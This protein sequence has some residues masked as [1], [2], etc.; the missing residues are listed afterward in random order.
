VVAKADMKVMNVMTTT[1]AAMTDAKVNRECLVFS[2]LRERSIEGKTVSDGFT[3]LYRGTGCVQEQTVFRAD[4]YC[5]SAL[6]VDVSNQR[7]CSRLEAA[8]SVFADIDT[9]LSAPNLP[10]A[11]LTSWWGG[12]QVF[13]SR[14]DMLIQRYKNSY[15]GMM[16]EM[17]TVVRKNVKPKA[18]A[19]NLL[20]QWEFY[21]WARPYEL[22]AARNP[23]VSTTTQLE[24]AV[25]YA[26]GKML[27]GKDVTVSRNTPLRPRYNKL[28]IPTNSVLG[29]VHVFL[30]WNADTDRTRAGIRIEGYAGIRVKARLKNEGETAFL[31]YLPPELHL[32][33]VPLCVPPLDRFDPV[34]H[35]KYRLTESDVDSIRA[36]IAAQTDHPTEHP[37]EDAFVAKLASAHQ[38]IVRSVIS[39]AFVEFPQAQ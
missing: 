26:R 9:F 31:A 32:V 22:T 2:R 4:D 5:Y 36:A 10:P 24:T 29:H 35:G 34:V 30:V 28:G 38:Q 19:C 6:A 18:N 13:A 1:E 8:Q 39:H 3:I 23:F 21:E 11:S 27:T 17:E 15:A 7:K 20:A 12:K 37:A 16:K 33:T 25:S 14:R